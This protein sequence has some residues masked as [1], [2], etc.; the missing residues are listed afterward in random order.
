MGKVDGN[1]T[2]LRTSNEHKMWGDLP[3]L[4]EELD[5]ASSDSSLPA[6]NRTNLHS[7]I[8]R[9]AG[10]GICGDAS[11]ICTSIVPR[12]PENAVLG[13]QGANW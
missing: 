13:S 7:F 12:R 10:V 11:W 4:I 6:T 8:A 5:I 9:L 1:D 2:V 3:Y